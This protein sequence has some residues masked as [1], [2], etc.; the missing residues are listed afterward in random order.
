ML[1]ERAYRDRVGRLAKY[2]SDNGADCVVVFSCYGDRDGNVV[3]LTGFRNGFPPG[4]DDNEIRGLGCSAVVV[5]AEGEVTV[6]S[7]FQNL[8]TCVGYFDKLVGERDFVKSLLGLLSGMRVKKVLLEGLD[9]IPSAYVEALRNSM[10]DVEFMKSSFLADMRALKSWEEVEMLKRAAEVGDKVLGECPNLLREGMREKELAA[11][12]MKIAYEEGVDYII[13]LRVASGE[14]ATYLT[15]P[16]AREKKI[17][18]EELVAVD[19]IGWLGDYALDLLRTYTL[20]RR[21]ETWEV[22]EK[23]AEATEEM[24]T[25]LK[26]G[27]A[28]DGLCRNLEDKL[29]DKNYTVSSFGHGIGVEVVEKPLL[30]RDNPSILQEGM[31]VC[32]EPRVMHGDKAA[33]VEDMVALTESGPVTLSKAPRVFR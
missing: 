14:K 20:S 30:V 32:V 2:V 28:V 18:R 31:V 10:L 25:G 8:K 27:E 3:Y 17:E 4:M 12:L 13:R 11:K 7:P 15:L 6:V 24:I 29:S 1:S 22:I 16:F 5:T 19:V 26:L 21:R 23:A 33:Q 9:V